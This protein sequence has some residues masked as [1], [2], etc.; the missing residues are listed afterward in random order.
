MWV[1]KDDGWSSYFKIFIKATVKTFKDS[2]L[3]ITVETNLK[4]VDFLDTFIAV[5]LL[6]SV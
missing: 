6:Q 1:Y 4:T 2:G 3:S 5:D